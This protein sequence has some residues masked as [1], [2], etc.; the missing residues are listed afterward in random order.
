[1]NISRAEIKKELNI[2]KIYFEA[3]FNICP[4]TLSSL[5]SNSREEPLVFYRQIGC[6]W[7]WLS[8]ESLQKTASYFNRTNHTTVINAIK[9]LLEQKNNVFKG[10]IEVLIAENEKL[11]QEDKL[12]LDIII[13]ENSNNRNYLL[14]NRINVIE[15]QIQN[16][17]N[18][19]E[20]IKKEI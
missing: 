16:I 6:V 15:K 5:K 4:F 14:Y 17:S 8:G 12:S 10:Y 13:E 2:D 19:V 9:V 3:F 7:I 11:S 1:M 18:E 20:L